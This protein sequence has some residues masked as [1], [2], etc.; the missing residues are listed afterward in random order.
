MKRSILIFVTKYVKYLK[1]ENIN[2]FKPKVMILNP[3]HCKYGCSILTSYLWLLL[4]V[5]FMIIQELLDVVFFVLDRLYKL[6]IISNL[7]KKF[8]SIGCP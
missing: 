1:T 6:K 3:Y 8:V 7:F 2:K 5:Y 4:N